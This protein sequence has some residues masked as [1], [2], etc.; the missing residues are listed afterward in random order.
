MRCERQP[1]CSTAS[2]EIRKAG[3][4]RP[5]AALQRS[6]SLCLD[7]AGY[8]KLS[9]FSDT[10]M[11]I[12]VAGMPDFGASEE[13]EVVAAAAAAAVAAAVSSCRSSSSS[14]SRRRSSSPSFCHP[15]GTTASALRGHKGHEVD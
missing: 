15:L 14:S 8:I 3:F 5:A 10:Y 11:L 7:P 12:A 2:R 4:A 1:E 9:K 6:M 13:E